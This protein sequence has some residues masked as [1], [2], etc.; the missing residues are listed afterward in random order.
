MVVGDINSKDDLVGHLISLRMAAIYDIFA[1]TCLHEF[2]KKWN[3]GEADPDEL[4]TVL[5]EGTITLRQ[6]MKQLAVFGNDAPVETKR[7]ANKFL[8]RN[9]LKEVF[10]ITQSYC[11]ES[12]QANTMTAEPWYKFA[13]IIVNSLSHNFRLDFRTHDRDQLPVSYKGETIDASMDR[14][15]LRMQLSALL[16]LIDDIIDFARNCAH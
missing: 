12:G 5:P 11:L 7:N 8:T 4:T 2:I 10:R 15:P 14:K 6:F 3:Q 9:L 1:Q 16:S 13:R